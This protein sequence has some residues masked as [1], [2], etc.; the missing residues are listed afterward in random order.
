ML[1]KFHCLLTIFFRDNST[2]SALNMFSNNSLRNVNL[3]FTMFIFY[4]ISNFIISWGKQ[5]TNKQRK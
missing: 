1:T 2:S 5:K 3:I 4:I